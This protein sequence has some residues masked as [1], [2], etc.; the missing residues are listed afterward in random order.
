ME[1]RVARSRLPLLVRHWASPSIST[2][3]SLA[4]AEKHTEH[5]MKFVQDVGQDS[6]TA[7]NSLISSY[8]LA[9]RSDF[10][11]WLTPRQLQRP[12][13]SSLHPVRSHKVEYHSSSPR[14]V[15]L[16]IRDRT[17]R[18]SGPRCCFHHQFLQAS[19]CLQGL[20]H[21]AGAGPL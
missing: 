1:L 11:R 15:H 5:A 13:V 2:K 17:L 21:V 7:R 4:I 9:T 6:R 18:A 14:F 3:G 12:D 20:C 16:L 19:D 8:A 10:P